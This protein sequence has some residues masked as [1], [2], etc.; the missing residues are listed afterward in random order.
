MQFGIRFIEFLGDGPELLRLAIAGE[1]A[2]FDSVWF[3]HDTFMRNTWVLT[4]AVACRTSRIRIGSVGTNPYTTDPCEIATYLATLDELSNGRAILG[5]GLNTCEMVEW[6]G[7]DASDY[8]VRTREATGLLRTLL[9]GE[10]AA[11]DGEAYHWSR[12]CYLRFKPLRNR[13]PIYVSAFGEDYLELS[14][15]IGNGSLPM[16]TPPASARYMVPPI[17]R[18]LE[19]NPDPADFT[20]SGCAWLSLAETRQAAADNMRKMIAYFGPYLEDEALAYIGLSRAD[21]QPMKELVDQ[22]QYEAAWALVTDDMLA[23]GIC[24][25]PEDVIREIETL[26]G[27]GIDEVNLGGPLGPDPD[28]A[29]RL[30]GE[31]VIPYFR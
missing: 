29:L 11:F 26:A 23:L 25:T 27:L 4:T 17:R 19:Q 22:G 8:I 9:N 16:L 21:L 5:L 3:P 30:M 7:I 24:G 12:Q 28:E 2:G 1:Q 10:V 14:G 15:Q 18:G 31:R 6:T 20:I 13:V